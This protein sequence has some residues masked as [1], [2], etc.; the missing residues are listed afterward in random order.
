M[1]IVIPALAA[2]PVPGQREA[3]IRVRLGRN[4]EL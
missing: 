2:E 1:A 3:P 4:D